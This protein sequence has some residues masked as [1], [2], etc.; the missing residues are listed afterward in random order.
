MDWKFHTTV[1]LD[2]ISSILFIIGSIFFHPYFSYSDSFEKAGVVTFAIGSVLFCMTSLR[3]LKADFHSISAISSESTALVKVLD[4][5]LAMSFCRN[6]IGSINGF[7]F[8]I[9]SLAFWPTFGGSGTIVGNWLCRCGSILG[10]ISSV[11]LLIRL[12][13]KSTKFTT[14]KLIT[15]LSLL[16]SINFFIG[17]VFYLLKGNH[18]DAFS[19]FWLLGSIAFL[20]SS[21]FVYKLPNHG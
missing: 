13:M 5:D 9:G 16:C 15:I 12:Q 2:I 1:L 4:I 10:I 14:M 17:G 3:Q 8:A 19:I 21:L 7:L 20:F 18:N 6:T 11:W